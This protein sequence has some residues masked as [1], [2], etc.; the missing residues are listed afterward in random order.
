M[1]PRKW[2]ASIPQRTVRVRMFAAHFAKCAQTAEEHIQSR[3]LCW[4]ASNGLV[5]ISA[6]GLEPATGWRTDV[7]KAS[8]RV[9]HNG[10]R[11]P[12]EQVVSPVDEARWP[13]ANLNQPILEFNHQP[14]RTLQ[15][16]TTPVP[17][18]FIIVIGGVWMVREGEPSRGA[19]GPPRRSFRGRAG[20]HLRADPQAVCLRCRSR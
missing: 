13:P 3:T 12:L 20:F 10:N 5:V 17:R 7:V 11:F 19:T 9:V 2:S 6:A 14:R 16:V 18:L 15:S 4:S 8:S 1:G